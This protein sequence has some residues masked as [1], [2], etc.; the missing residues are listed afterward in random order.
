MEKLELK[1]F[2]PYLPYGLKVNYK[3][4]MHYGTDSIIDAI[5]IMGVRIS[6]IELW[7][8]FQNIKPIL[9][10]LSDYNEINS[11]AFSELNCDMS[12]QIEINELATGQENL[13]SLCYKTV[14]VCLRNHI[15]VFGLIEKGLAVPLT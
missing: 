3:E 14:E 13:G 5:D 12:D 15:D 2:A 10:P 6:G 7:V 9:R 8:L 11:I 1:H 4:G